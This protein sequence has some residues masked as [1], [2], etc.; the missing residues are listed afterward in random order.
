M[1]VLLFLAGVLTA[2]PL[3]LFAEGAKKLPL[4]QV[5][6]LQISLRPLHYV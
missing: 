3:L 2:I 6:I 1:M 5:G 4:Y